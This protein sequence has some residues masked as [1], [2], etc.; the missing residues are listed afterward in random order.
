[1]YKH[2]IQLLWAKRRIR[3]EKQYNRKE[4]TPK[5]EGGELGEGSGL[6]RHSRYNIISYYNN[7]IIDA[8]GYFTIYQR[9]DGKWQARNNNNN[10]II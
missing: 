5:K 3:I 4:K 8:C 6:S 9:D 7:I 1:M 2:I 10:N